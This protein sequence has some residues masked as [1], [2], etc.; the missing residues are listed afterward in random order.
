MFLVMYLPSCI[1]EAFSP[2]QIFSYIALSLV[3]TLEEFHRLCGMML[4]R[5]L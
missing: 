5:H 3:K 4:S 1:A 2:Y